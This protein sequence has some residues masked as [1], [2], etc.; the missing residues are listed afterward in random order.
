V[1]LLSVTLWLWPL[2]WKGS[3]GVHACYLL[4]T[5]WFV[6]LFLLSAIP[7]RIN[8]IYHLIGKNVAKGYQMF[9]A[10]FVALIGFGCFG[11]FGMIATVVYR[12]PLFYI[13]DSLLGLV[14][15]LIFRLRRKEIAERF[16][17]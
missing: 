8:P 9:A 7:P 2:V 16:D 1:V 15:V 4:A 5:L 10:D 17:T 13:A 6:H 12:N 14:F 3:Y 11:M